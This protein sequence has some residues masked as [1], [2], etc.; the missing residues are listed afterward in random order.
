MAGDVV[1]A[2]LEAPFMSLDVVPAV[3]PEIPLEFV[4]IPDELEPVGSVV[5]AVLLE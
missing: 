5:P 1:A 3:E 2:V 4:A